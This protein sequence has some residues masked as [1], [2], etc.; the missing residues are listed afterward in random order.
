MRGGSFFTWSFS[1]LKNKRE[2]FIG[3][4]CLVILFLVL[5]KKKKKKLRAVCVSVCVHVCV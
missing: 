4:F 3:K 5:K 1:V 2:V